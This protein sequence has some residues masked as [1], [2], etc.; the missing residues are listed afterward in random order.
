MAGRGF[1]AEGA[2]LNA[3]ADNETVDVGQGSGGVEEGQFLFR[4]LAHEEENLLG[5]QGK[6]VGFGAVI[7]NL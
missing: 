7:Q 5:D 1:E 4:L 2:A 6:E 3:V